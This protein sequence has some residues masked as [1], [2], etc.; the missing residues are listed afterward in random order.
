MTN[1]Q[2]F[3]DEAERLQ[4]GA[5]SS[6]T[7]QRTVMS[8]AYYGCYHLALAFAQSTGYKFDNNAGSG[9]HQHLM[10]YLQRAARDGELRQALN[11]LVTLRNRRTR[12]DYHLRRCIT[13]E[14]S[15]EALDL[16]REISVVLNDSQQD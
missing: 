5:R 9:R 8:R 11:N 3:L 14:D 6:E 15:R 10:D 4:Q 13:F 1:P 16:A 12:A 7:R 2:D